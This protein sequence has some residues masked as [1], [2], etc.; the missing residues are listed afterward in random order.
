M[1][2]NPLGLARLAVALT[3]WPALC[4]AERFDAVL[5]ADRDCPATVST[6]RDDNPGT[7]RLLPGERYRVLGSNK[8]EATH[9]ELRIEGASP[10]QRWVSVDCGRLEGARSASDQLPRPRSMDG[11]FVLAASWQPA[12]CERR[13]GTRE[14]RGQTDA[15]LDARQFSLHGLWPQ[16]IGNE[17]CGVGTADRNLSESGDWGRLPTPDLSPAVR[18]TLQQR[19]PGYLSHLHRYEW[20]KHGTCYGTGADSYFGQALTL[21]DQLNRSE[22]RVLF[23]DNIGKRVRAEQIRHAFDRAFGRG[24]GDRVRLVCYDGLITEL[25]IGLKG[26]IG[27]DSGLAELIREAPPR[28]VRCRGGWVDRAGAGR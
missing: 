4:G 16:P 2:T 9:Y 18:Q 27:D 1:L 26:A 28:S 6:K 14:C 12:F 3:L 15:R 19:M 20:L 7:I 11:Q 10:S 13:P 21:L 5:I 17:Y 23:E 25:R 8:S 24:A 22:V